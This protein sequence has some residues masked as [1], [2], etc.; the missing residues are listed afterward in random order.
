LVIESLKLERRKSGGSFWREGAKGIKS[1]GEREKGRE[2]G[3]GEKGER[4]T[5]FLD[6]L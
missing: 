1:Y 6:G 3:G 4:E 5:A 2:R